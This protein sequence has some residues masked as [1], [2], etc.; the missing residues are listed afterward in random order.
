MP[1]ELNATQGSLLGFLFDGPKTGW[2]LLQEIE[3]GSVP[4][5]ERHAQPRLPGA[6]HAA[7]PAPR[8]RRAHRGP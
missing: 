7:G 1:G 8:H 4:L 2:D 5:L 3:R 6:A